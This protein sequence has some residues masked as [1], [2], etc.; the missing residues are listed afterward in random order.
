MDGDRD[1]GA[2]EHEYLIL[3]A[4]PAG[5]Q[6]GH[7]LAHA[8]HTYLI[9]E[10][11]DT[12]GTFFT[13]Y[14]RHRKLISINKVYTGYD[15]P[16]I[17]LRWDWNSLLSE[18]GD[19]RLADYSRRYFPPADDLVRYLSD[20]AQCYELNVRLST[21]VVRVERPRA[22]GPFHACDP[23]GNEF[24]GRRLVV[25]TGV[26]RPYVPPIPGA[27]LA[28]RYVN[29]S[30]DPN[31][32]VNQR[33]LVVGKGNS[34]FETADNLVETAAVVHVLSPN[35]ITMAWK[36][37]FAGHLRAINNNLL[38]TYPMKSQNA[39]LDAAIERIARRDGGEY[40]VSVRYTHACGETEDLTYDR[41]ILCTGFRFDASIFAAECRPELVLNNRFPAQTAEWESTNVPGLY[42]AGTLTQARD[43]KR[44]ASGFIH[45][46]RYNTRSL[47]R[48]LERKH[49][50]RPWPVREVGATPQGLVDAVLARAN[51]SSALWQQFGFLC[52]LIVVSD[53]EERALYYEEMPLAYIHDTELGAHEHYY[54]V[55]LE[56]GKIL[57][58]PF[59]LPRQPDPGRAHESTFLHPVVRR[60]NGRRLVAEHHV[61]EDLRGEWKKFEPHVMPLNDFFTRQLAPSMARMAVA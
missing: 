52:D 9:L 18:D 31:D 19:L 36:S 35:P 6:L 12:P 61:L 54:T 20:Y 44:S 11:G 48:M 41:V 1:T 37:Q 8:G 53:G 15:D 26:S 58:D 43:F 57:G 4:G 38:D 22:D 25:A 30:I 47:F 16:E 32:F 7:H 56:F 51:R 5:L 34:G 13:H 49:H 60:W 29:A 2:V 21:R 45:G 3:G 14:P 55:T 59:D 50:G 42:F 17:N 27:E 28:E 40:V 39:V 10:A 46:F 24:V 23:A 33:V